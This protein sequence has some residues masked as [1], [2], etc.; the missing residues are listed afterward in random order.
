MTPFR[1]I[2]LYV[3][4]SVMKYIISKDK[5]VTTRDSRP[6]G[7]YVTFNLSVPFENLTHEGILVMFK[8]SLTFMQ[9]HKLDANT[10]QN[11]FIEKV[12]AYFEEIGWE[13]EVVTLK[14]K[15]ICTDNSNPEGIMISSLDE[16]K[17][18]S[19]KSLLV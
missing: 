10:L 16:L 18:I 7:D 1:I 6:Y 14:T 4:I 11:I 5:P 3:N 19:L 8:V 9:E 12:K 2:P 17:S 13:I 15:T